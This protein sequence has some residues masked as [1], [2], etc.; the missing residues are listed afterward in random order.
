MGALPD[1]FEHGSPFSGLARLPTVAPKEG[2]R[3]RLAGIAALRDRMAPTRVPERSSGHARIRW[4]VVL[5]ISILVG[6]LTASVAPDA[7]SAAGLLAGAITLLAQRTARNTAHPDASLPLPMRADLSPTATPAPPRRSTA[8]GERSHLEYARE[9]IVAAATEGVLDPDARDR[10][11]WFLAWREASVAETVMTDQAI[12]PAPASPPARSPL[13]QARYDEWPTT[14]MIPAPRDARRGPA[15]GS[16]LE[17]RIGLLR[18]VIASDVAVHGLAYLGVLLLFSGSLGFML[19]SFGSVRVGLRPLAEFSM[20]AVL[21]GS[22]WFL[23][24]RRAPFVATALGLLGGL[25]L[26]V[27]LFA[28]FVDGVP[29]PPELHGAALA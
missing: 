7:A 8:D 13:P 26:P 22:A 3:G 11:L 27:A 19:F 28:S 1:R 21:L 5:L 10:L 9:L 23:R 20:P 12:P 4:S 18:G 16:S 17:E 24:R 14:A 6:G 29:I 25:L 15:R 2:E